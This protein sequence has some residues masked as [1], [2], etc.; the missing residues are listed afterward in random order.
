MGNI[1]RM[2]IS[3]LMSLG[4]R[5][6]IHTECLHDDNIWRHVKKFSKYKPVWFITAPNN[7][8]SLTKEMHWITLTKKEYYG[9]WVNRVKWLKKHNQEFGLHIHFGYVCDLSKH[10]DKQEKKIKEALSFESKTGISFGGRFAAGWWH[11]DES[12]LELL[13]KYGFTKVYFISK[14]PFQYLNHKHYK[15][16]E[17]IPVPVYCHDFDLVSL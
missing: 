15:N 14:N 1:D 8:Y 16:I 2:S 10:I 11:F 4:Y 12:T 3:T 7:S 13:N 17:L 5:V 9:R 6:H